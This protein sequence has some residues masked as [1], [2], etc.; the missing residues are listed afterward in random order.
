MRDSDRWRAVVYTIMNLLAPQNVRNFLSSRGT[1]NFSRRALLHEFSETQTD[2][3]F[4]FFSA[5]RLQFLLALV[6]YVRVGGG[7]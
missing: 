4:L 6:V 2:G 1:V 3:L 7:L 5:P